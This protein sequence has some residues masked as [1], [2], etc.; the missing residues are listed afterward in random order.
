M[1]TRWAA[2]RGQPEADRVLDLVA[3]YVRAV[4]LDPESAGESW[5]VTV[6][7]HSGSVIR[8]NAGGQ[9]VMYAR[10]ERS[11]FWRV[12]FG[13]SR[14]V[15]E[16]VTGDEANGPGNDIGEQVSDED[17]PPDEEQ[18]LIAEDQHN[19]VKPVVEQLWFG[20]PLATAE[21]WLD[22]PRFV[23]ALNAL[24]AERDYR[25]PQKTW[26]QPLPVDEIL[27]RR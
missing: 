21:D 17:M 5:G 9:Q 25:M 16:G 10:R 14:A 7:T 6:P 23:A 3:H 11:E 8:V 24:V 15:V 19:N 2:F 20:L 12:W 4:A 1:D 13:A 22:D 18:I 27:R 26:S